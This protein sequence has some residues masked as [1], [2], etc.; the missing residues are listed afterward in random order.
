Q[1]GNIH[2]DLPADDPALVEAYLGY[3]AKQL[4]G[5]VDGIRTALAL[6]PGQPRWIR[7]VTAG[8]KRLTGPGPLAGAG[9]PDVA[10]G[11]SRPK[12]AEDRR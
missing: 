6:P 8:L 5:G 2:L 11:A 7:A 1:A 3:L 10:L 4:P 12:K 9:S